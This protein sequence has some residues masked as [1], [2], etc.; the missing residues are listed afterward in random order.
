MNILQF[1]RE[2]VVRR[3]HKGELTKASLRHYEICQ[4]IA[5][6]KTQEQ[7][8]EEFNLTDDA[9]VRYIKKKKCPECGRTQKEY[10][11]RGDVH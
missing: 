7:I 1:T 2:D 3:I 11:S 6:K 5:Q 9:H 10:Y 4:A 8:A